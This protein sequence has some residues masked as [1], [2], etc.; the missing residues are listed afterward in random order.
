[1]GGDE[2]LQGLEAVGEH[3]EPRF[4]VI[5]LLQ[6]LVQ[7]PDELAGGGDDVGSEIGLAAA[8]T[9]LKDRLG[10]AGVGLFSAHGGSRLAAVGIPTALDGLLHDG[11]DEGDSL[12]DRVLRD[13]RIFLIGRRSAEPCLSRLRQMGTDWQVLA[14][15][16]L[17]MGTG[18]QAVLVLGAHNA[19]VLAP[20]LLASLRPVFR[21]LAGSLGL[22]PEMQGRAGLAG[23]EENDRLERLG[24]T[25]GAM[26]SVEDLEAELEALRSRNRE[27]ED[28]LQMAQEASAAGEA[29]RRV[30]IEG[31]RMQ[32]AQLESSL[33]G[34]GGSEDPEDADDQAPCGTC[35]DLQQVAEQ[36]EKSVL[37]LQEEIEQLKFS[38]EVAAS[39]AHVDLADSD[40]DLAPAPDSPES[41]SLGAMADAA[42][43]ELIGDL[44][45]EESCEGIG[46][47]AEAG[48]ASPQTEGD[49]TAEIPVSMLQLEPEAEPERALESESAPEVEVTAGS[50]EPWV[51]CGAAGSSEMFDELAE[52]AGAH[53]LEM[54]SLE[55]DTAPEGRRLVLANLLVD[56]PDEIIAS[57]GES[58]EGDRMIGY[59]ADGGQGAPLGEID[60]LSAHLTTE[61]AMERLGRDRGLPRHTLLV[62]ERLREMAGLREALT[63]AGSAVAMACD[64]RQALDLL[65]IVQ[66][67]DAAILD[68]AVESTAAL[69]LGARL[70]QENAGGSFQLFFLAPDSGHKAA[71]SPDP[72]FAEVFR[73]FGI[74]DLQRLIAPWIRLH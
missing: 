56:D 40:S 44:V 51:L 8:V 71:L 50:A 20:D 38:A 1:M 63:N 69:A 29:A 26:P 35:L 62:S 49:I 65:E 53:N 30:E 52:F 60:W 24:D 23:R 19:T 7:L 33:A 15:V 67:P 37:S 64:A 59:I 28:L 17:R 66:K 43:A 46:E 3:A 47:K 22:A 5:S 11:G 32:I 57:I 55:T 36:A 58:R 48:E 21:F 54:V 45:G 41:G 13:E 70:V 25:D 72:A 31:A 42:V 14:L 18:S 12:I 39:V 2:E 61:D 16:P 73:P 74:I 34:A 9:V 27:M 6:S 4:L 68:V 10:L